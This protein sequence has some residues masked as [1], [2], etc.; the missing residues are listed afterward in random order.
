MRLG[1]LMRWNIGR[2]GNFSMTASPPRSVRLPYMRRLSR[3]SVSVR[4]RGIRSHPVA[5]MPK[6]FPEPR[7]VDDER[8][9][10]DVAAFVASWS[11]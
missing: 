4:A 6:I 8:D 7:S 5:P 1:A 3:T 9:V 2:S 11:H 10:R